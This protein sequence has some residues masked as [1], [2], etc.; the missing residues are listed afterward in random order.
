MQFAERVAQRFVVIGENGKKP[1][2]DHRL[3]GFKTGK[4][5]RGAASFDDGVAHAGVGDA[6][7]VGDDEADVAGFEF[8]ES[9]RF[10][11]ERAEL[12]DFVDVVAGA[13]PNLH[14]IGDAAFHHADEDHGSAVWIEPGIEDQCLQRILRAAFGRGNARDD[15]FENVVDAEAAFGADGQA[16]RARQWPERFQFVL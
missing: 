13:E 7:D 10:G 4:R 14:V 11:S 1:G 12:L 3:G 5:R 8:I 9:D 15:G 6:L 16:R 2:E